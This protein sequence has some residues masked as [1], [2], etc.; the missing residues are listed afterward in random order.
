MKFLRTGN[1]RIAFGPQRTFLLI[2]LLAF[3]VRVIGVLASHQYL[4]VERYELE[5]TALSLAQTGV[6]GNPYAIPT[7]P[8]AHVAPGYTLILAAIFKLFGTGMGAELVKQIFSSAVSAFQCALILPVARGL[9]L[10]ARVGLLTAVFKAL[11]PVKFG[12]ETMGDWEA[13]YTAIALMLLS[14]VMFRIYREKN[15]KLKRAVLAGF[16]WGIGV[17]FAPVLLP[18]F[19]ISVAVGALFASNREQLGYL[20]FCAVELLLVAAC[21]APWAIRNDRALGA[22]VIARTNLGIE[23]RISNN[24]LAS[25]DE[26]V[27]FDHGLY[28]KY[29]PL[30]NPRE[31]ALLRQMG[32]IAYNEHAEQQAL[33]WIRAHP[34]KF[35]ELSMQRARLF[36]FYTPHNVDLLQQIKYFLLALIHVLG[37][38]GLVYLFRRNRIAAVVL[39]LILVVYP[40]PNY[41]IHVGPRQSYPVDWILVLLMFSLMVPL[42]DTWRRRRRPT[43]AFTNSVNA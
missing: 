14:V 8:S 30:Q 27:N 25:A 37:L 32:E 35:V 16:A 15:F 36:W 17:L 38:F 18:I 13:P 34:G 3:V 28:Q 1:Y 2:F 31:A 22:P 26:H 6:Y 43:E 12:T 21:L 24:D 19:A 29:H 5:R 40:L 41:L 39:S 11:L 4:N 33:T 9:L 20:R 10:D 42:S 7:G 23:L